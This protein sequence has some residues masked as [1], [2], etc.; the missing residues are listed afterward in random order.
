MLRPLIKWLL[1]AFS[2]GCI[3]TGGFLACRRFVSHVTGFATLLGIDLVSH[4]W[5]SALAVITVPFYFLAGSAF[6]AWIVERRIQRGTNPFYALPLTVAGLLLVLAAIGGQY[7]SFG[8]FG[9]ESNLGPY[10]LFV[11]TLCLACGIL[12]AAVTVGTGTILR[13]SHL[14]GTTTDFGTG[15]VRWLCM[16]ADSLERYLEY[17]LNCMRGATIFFFVSGAVA[18]AYL[19]PRWHYAGFWAPALVVFGVAAGLASKRI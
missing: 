5:V 11:V 10:Y 17:R 16:P 8:A 7:G 12:N 3:N 2:C 9:A 1:L 18:G 14:T 19:V 6:T 13:A 15:M 4:D